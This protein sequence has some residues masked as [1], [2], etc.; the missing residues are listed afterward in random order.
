MTLAEKIAYIRGLADGMKLDDG[1]DEV[2]LIKEIISVLEDV[3]YDIEEQDEIMGEMQEQLDAVDEDLDEL[4]EFVYECDEDDFDDC[5]C[6][7]C[8]DDDCDCCDFDD[9]YFEVECPSCGETICIDE[10]ILDEGSIECPACHENLEFEFDDC[11]CEE[12]D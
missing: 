6:G 4:E 1:K 5:D 10:S 12:D 11:D 7:C 9:D 3:A 8:D 2:K